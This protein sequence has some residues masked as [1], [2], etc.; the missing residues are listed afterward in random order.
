M[1]MTLIAVV[2]FVALFGLIFLRVPV[3]IAMGIVGIGGFAAVAGPAPALNILAQSPIRIATDGNFAVVPMFILMG[4]FVS[5]SGMSRDLFRAANAFLGHLRGGLAIA[6]IAACAGF[7]AICGSS[8]ATAATFSKVSYPEMLL[9]GYPKKFSAGVVAAGG[10]LGIMIPP[11]TIL[12]IYGI[13]GQQ[14]IGKLFIAGIVPGILAAFLYMMT[15]Y[16]IGIIQPHVL[17]RGERSTWSQR[18]EAFNKIWAVALLFFFIVGGIY[19]G[20]FTINEAAGMGAAGALILALAQRRLTSKELLAALVDTV[21]TS[22]AIFTILIG[23]LLFGYF[24]AVTQVPQ[25]LASFLT[26]LELNRYVILIIILA[27]YILLGCVMDEIAILVLTVPIILPIVLQ[28][29]FDPIWFGILLVTVVEIGLIAPPVGMNIFV[30]VTVLRGDISL[31]D[32]YRGV[33]PFILTDIVRLGI[34]IAFPVITMGLLA[35]R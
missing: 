29:G 23:A 35:A 27:A 7:S 6:T 32:A 33:T 31:S 12:V 26:G 34:L 11:S 4:A 13:I 3:G 20:L 22:A 16:V 25:Q 30:I 5:S 17:V 19:G 21:R 9:Y 14:D 2:G 15:I 24:L 10:T 18:G 28:L 8:V 1:S